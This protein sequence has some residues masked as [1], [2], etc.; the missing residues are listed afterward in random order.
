MKKLDPREFGL[1]DNASSPAESARVSGRF[2]GGGISKLR[3]R[4]LVFWAVIV[5]FAAVIGGYCYLS[6]YPQTSAPRAAQISVAT[7]TAPL[8]A[9]MQDEL[10]YVYQGGLFAYNLNTN[11]TEQIPT[12]FITPSSSIVHAQ[13]LG[14]GL[15]GFDVAVGNWSS[16]SSVYVLDLKS[17]ETAKKLDIA[18]STGIQSFDFISPDEF[19]YTES[20][21][22]TS[23]SMPPPVDIF[24]VAS[25]TTKQ[26]GTGSAMIPYGSIVSHSPNGRYIFFAEQIYDTRTDRWQDISKGCSGN[27]SVWLN[28]NIVVLDSMGDWGSRLC[29]YDMASKIQTVIVPLPGVMSFGILGD[30]IIYSDAPTSSIGAPFEISAYD[31]N[32]GSSTVLIKNALMMPYSGRDLGNLEGVVYQPL[33]AVNPCQDLGCYGGSATGSLMLFNPQTASS[34]PLIFQSPPPSE[35]I[36]F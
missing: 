17:G 2:Y 21:N 32:T 15:L 5:I 25:G 19:A 29:Y 20:E 1:N 23:G 36:V 22:A 13:R 28:N 16:S 12:S 8:A 9:T 27:N 31:V 30:R 24:L 11:E 18:P 7:S 10:F 33:A 6:F 14:D 3:K 4:K 34:V 26:I 35:S